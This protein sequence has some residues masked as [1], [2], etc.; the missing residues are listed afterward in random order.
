MQKNAPEDTHIRTMNLN[1]RIAAQPAIKCHQMI[2][3]TFSVTK[4]GRINL[5]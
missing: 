1:W 5:A 3:M 2:F 4:I